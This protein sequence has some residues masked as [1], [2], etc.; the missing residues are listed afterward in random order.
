MPIEAV[1][2][3]RRTRTIAPSVQCDLWGKAAGR[4][5]FAGCNK[6]LWKSPVTQESVNIS[7]KA[8][9]YSFSDGGPRGNDGLSPDEINSV[10]NLMLLCYDCHQ[11]IDDKQD[12]GRYTASLLRR[13][14]AEHER[15]IERITG[16]DPEKTSHILLYGANIG[17]HSSPLQY[18]QAAVALFPKRYPASDTPLQVSTLSSSFI[19]RDPE[20][21]DLEAKSLRRKFEQ[22]VRERIALGD[23]KHLSV[24]ALAPQPLLILLGTLIGDIVSADVYQRHREPQTW[25]W[26]KT[27]ELADFEVLEPSAM[28]GPPAL[29]IGLSGTVT[30]DRISRAVGRDAATWVI[31]TPTPNNDL[32][33]S[34]QQLAELRRVYRS[35]FDRVKAIYGAEEILHVFPVAGVSAAV[36]FGRARMPKA[37]MPWQIYDENTSRGGFLPALNIVNGD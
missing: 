5:E 6:A 26:P 2:A 30:P 8:H 37:D 7:Q 23:I 17:D 31:T 36:E 33:K 22:K 35:V 3:T 12:G 28:T 24:F 29:V 27:A 32:I 1:Q 19:D 4:C 13:M 11:K 9:I 25:E 16:I 14:K 34:R 18:D 15:R 21:W 20:F 10:G